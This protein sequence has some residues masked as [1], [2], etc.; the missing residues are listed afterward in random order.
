MNLF[1]W[2]EE[3]PRATN[4]RIAPTM[5]GSTPYYGT[6]SAREYASDIVRMAMSRKCNEA[7]KLQPR[8]VRINQDGQ[9][10]TV[11]N[12][13]IARVLRRPNRFMSSADFMSKC[14]ALREITKNCFIYPMYNR[15]GNICGLY[16]LRPQTVEFYI[17]GYIRLTFS[18]GTELCCPYSEIIHWRK[19]YHVDD[20]MG[21]YENSDDELMGW[22]NTY[23]EIM[24]SIAKA[25]KC[26]LNVTGVMQYGIPTERE[27]LKKERDKFENDLRE[28][29]SSVL[30]M[31]SKATYTPIN[32]DAVK[33]IDEP[34]MKFLFEVILF[35][36]GVSLAILKG[37]FTPQQKAAFYD[38]AMEDGVI[39]FGQAL[40]MTLISDD[41]LEAGERIEM[42]TNRLQFASLEEV[43]KYLQI[44]V[45][46]SAVNR[47]EIRGAV[48]L[49]PM[50]DG[51]KV[52]QSLNYIDSAKANKYQVG[53]DTDE[54]EEESD[55]AETE[56][57]EK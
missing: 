20:F 14:W 12:S 44:A 40:E 3:R 24:D 48:G 22:I 47:N 33:F 7:I 23:N 35:N 31:D 28:G 16:P 11:A 45:P 19:D 43:C 6:P 10:E 38:T 39:T 2:I 55:N 29:N 18:N 4:K 37:D 46:A 50:A 30:F 32:R 26:Q 57:T 51:D 49:P 21:G 41:Q 53:E 5:D 8:H 52:P 9:Q 42:Y 1:N 54:K 13:A 36:S 15:D 56:N 27:N 34:T 25:A 17:D